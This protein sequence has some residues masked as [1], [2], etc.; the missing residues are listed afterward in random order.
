MI[1]GLGLFCNE[2]LGLGLELALISSGILVIE[3]G[4][5]VTSP[6]YE[7][8]GKLWIRGKNHALIRQIMKLFIYL[9]F[10]TDSLCNWLMFNI[11][12]SVIVRR[13]SEFFWLSGWHLMIFKLERRSQGRVVSGLFI[14]FLIVCFF[15]S[16]CSI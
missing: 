3:D 11:Y 9:F 7:G 4:I 2:A 14:C 12:H 10:G 8:N 5:F 15:F 1:K 16:F 6:G 13:Q